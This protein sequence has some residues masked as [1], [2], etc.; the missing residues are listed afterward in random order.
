MRNNF[1]GQDLQTLR[2]RKY[3]LASM[4]R[5]PS[6]LPGIFR[7]AM[8][9]RFNRSIASQQLGFHPPAGGFLRI[10]RR[11]GKQMPCSMR[12][13]LGGHPV[14]YKD[15]LVT[16]RVSVGEVSMEGGVPHASA[17]RRP[18]LARCVPLG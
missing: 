18:Y 1:T 4:V 15:H 7:S 17:C 16:D 14:T 9:G 13:F 3:Q 12:I 10:H 5:S 11:E 8:S 2:G 6:L